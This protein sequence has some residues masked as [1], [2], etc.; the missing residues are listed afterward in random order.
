MNAFAAT[1]DFDLADAPEKAH[2]QVRPLSYSCDLRSVSRGA[3]GVLT[4]LAEASVAAW[5]PLFV[6]TCAPVVSNAIGVVREFRSPNTTF[7]LSTVAAPGAQGVDDW[8]LVPETVTKAEVDELRRIWAL[9]YPG[10]VEFDFG[11]AD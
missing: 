1:H 7:A 11:R 6:R 3:T 2:L 10:D 8:T 9:P 5:M 4:D